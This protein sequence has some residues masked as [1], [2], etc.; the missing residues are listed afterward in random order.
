MHSCLSRSCGAALLVAAL[1]LPTSAASAQGKSSACH[2][3]RRVCGF[4]VS[5]ERNLTAMLVSS[6]PAA[7]EQYFADDGTL[8]L[9]DGRRWTKR[10]AIAAIRMEP[11]MESSRLVRANVRQFGAVAV[12]FW[13]ERWRA[14]GARNGRAVGTDT[15]LLRNGRWQIVASQEARPVLKPAT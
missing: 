9:A 14:P 15:W 12:V 6:N 7:I 11:R 2:G 8:S 3:D 13:D 1:F 10:E 4:I 5:A